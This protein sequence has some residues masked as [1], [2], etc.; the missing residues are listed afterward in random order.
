MGLIIILF[1][2]L[3]HNNR[4]TSYRPI[5]QMYV[6]K[7]SWLAPSAG[8]HSIY[9]FTFQSDGTLHV[10]TLEKVYKL[11]RCRRQTWHTLASYEPRKGTQP[12]SRGTRRRSWESTIRHTYMVSFFNDTG[13]V[14]GR[15][16]PEIISL[17]IYILVRWTCDMHVF[18]IFI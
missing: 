7:L 15:L 5:P 10:T 17:P 3:T 1:V 18:T 11:A 13:G 8:M 6:C 9:S 16:P 4:Y 12:P 2:K 14:D